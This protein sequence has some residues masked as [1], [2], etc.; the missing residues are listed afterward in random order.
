MTG[1]ISM[2]MLLVIGPGLIPEESKNLC[3]TFISVKMCSSLSC[4]M[5]GCAVA[6]NAPANGLTHSFASIAA[7]MV[8]ISIQ[9]AF[10]LTLRLK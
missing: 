7:E 3:K 9:A 1:S 10:L 2:A 8:F 6:V 5:T 4:V